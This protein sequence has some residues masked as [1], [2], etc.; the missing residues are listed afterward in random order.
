VKAGT[1]V[2]TVGV[3]RAAEVEQHD[4]GR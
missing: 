3:E 1:P 2:H 4:V